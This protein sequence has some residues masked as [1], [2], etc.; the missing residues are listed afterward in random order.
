MGENLLHLSNQIESSVILEG[1]Y[2]L[3]LD[4]NV[5]M[6]FESYRQGVVS[7]GLL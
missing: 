5:V 2:R 6:R 3:V 1:P 7:E 4:S